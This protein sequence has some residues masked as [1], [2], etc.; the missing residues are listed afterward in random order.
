MIRLMLGRD[1]E[2]EMLDKTKEWL[3]IEGNKFTLVLD[4]LHSYRGT[5]GAEVSYLI[6][7]FLDRIGILNKP[8]K[9][10]IICSSASITNSNESYDFLEDFFGIKADSFQI[11]G[12]EDEEIDS[13]NLDIEIDFVKDI[14]DEKPD[15]LDEK[16]IENLNNSFYEIIKMLPRDKR[17]LKSI[18]QTI[19]K[20]N[21]DVMNNL[22]RLFDTICRDINSTSRYR[23]HY[24]IRR[25]RE[26]FA[27]VDRDCTAVDKKTTS[28]KRTVGKIYLEQRNRCICGSKVL[29]LHYCDSCEH[30]AL[31]GWILMK[32]MMT[33]TRKF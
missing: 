31:G 25:F 6:K 29:T 1:H 3:E 13:K 24:F 11:I 2:K 28:S 33:I 21:E 27:C 19:F 26:V 30:L 22:E 16:D 4:E 12:D 7:R 8:D 18:S 23:I 20:N 9:L 17:D 10:Q 32:K 15:R 14:L 5:S